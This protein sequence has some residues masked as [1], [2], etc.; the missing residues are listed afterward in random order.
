M[1]TRVNFRRVGGAYRFGHLYN[2]TDDRVLAN[3]ISF[4][5]ILIGHNFHN[6]FFVL[7]YF[8]FVS[9]YRHIFY[10][11]NL[12]RNEEKKMKKTLPPLYRLWC[13]NSWSL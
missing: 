6:L 10:D 7:N 13:F 12:E 9:F 5:W 8:Q 2:K 1:N 4:C 11:E 3:I